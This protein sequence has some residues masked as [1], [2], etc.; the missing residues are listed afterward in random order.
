[1]RL[2][3]SQAEA[4]ALAELGAAIAAAGRGGWAFERQKAAAFVGG[5]GITLG[6]CLRGQL[7][8]EICFA[9]DPDD[10]G[11]HERIDDVF[12]DRILTNPR[13]PNARRWLGAAP[14]LQRAPICLRKW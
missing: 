7:F 5:S 8:L 2:P 3:A 6:F 12:H 11:S 14:Y 4:L 1:L 13:V 9:A 10:P